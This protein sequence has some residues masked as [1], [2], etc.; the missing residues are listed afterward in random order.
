LKNIRPA[1]IALP[2][3]RSGQDL[4]KCHFFTMWL[5]VCLILIFCVSEPVAAGNPYSGICQRNAFH[6]R[7]AVLAAV[8]KLQAPLPRFHLT[9][10][11]TILRG[12]R[13]LLKVELPGKPAAKAESYI[14]AEGQKDG[15]LEVLQIDERA[16]SVK[17]AF[18]GTVTNLTFDKMAPP[19]PVQKAPTVFARPLRRVLYTR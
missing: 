18:S 5:L 1:E 7:P 11:T 14:L 8:S 4:E 19:P 2:D 6:L 17:I 3:T 15:P 16:A 9:G 10:I 13:A 12:K